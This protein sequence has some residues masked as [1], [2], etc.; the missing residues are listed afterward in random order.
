MATQFF[1]LLP[2]RKEASAINPDKVGRWEDDSFNF[3]P[4]LVKSLASGGKISDFDHIDSIPDVWARPLLFQMAL[5]DETHELHPRIL[6]EWRSILA[7]LALKEIRHL[8][9]STLDVHLDAQSG[10]I[11]QILRI[12]APEDSIS[13]STNWDHLYVIYFEDLPLAMTSPTTLVSTAADYPERFSGILKEPWSRDNRTLTDPIEF[14]TLEELAALRFWI[15][16]LQQTLRSTIPLQD[17]EESDSCMDLFRLLD[18]FQRDLSA[19]LR[20]VD[21]SFNLTQSNLGF[22]VGI[23]RSLNQTIAAREATSDDSAVRLLSTRIQSWDRDIIL[24]SPEMVRDFSSELGIPASQLTIWQGISANDITEEFLNSG[25]A[26]RSK[27]GRVTL[28]DTNWIRPEEFFTDQMAVVEPGNAIVGSIPIAGSS[29]LEEEDLTA[30]L[31][32]KNSLLELFD[33]KE[34]A[35][36]ISLEDTPEEI[37]V[38]FEFPLSGIHGEASYKFQKSYPKKDLVYLQTMIPVIEIFPDFKRDGWDKY[39]LYYE[40]TKA[41]ENS[42]ELGQ[43][44]FYVTPFTEDRLKK[45]PAFANRS[46]LQLNEFPEALLCSVNS[47]GLT[48]EV[49][50]ILLREPRYIER[51]IDLTWQIGIDFGTSSTMIYYREKTPRP[52]TLEPNLFQVTDSGAARGRTFI[53]FIPSTSEDQIDGSFLSIFHLLNPKAVEIQPLVDGHVFNLTVDRIPTFESL[54]RVDANLKWQDSD[55]GRK[56]VAAFVKQ[57]CLQT[58][59]AAARRG[60]ESIQWNFSFPSAFSNEQRLAFLATCQESVDEVYRNS[61]FVEDS[62][63]IHAWEESK[64]AAFYFNKLSEDSKRVDTNFTDGAIILDI[65]AGTTDVSIISG[66]PA[67][68]IYHTSIQFAGRYFF[69]PLFDHYELFSPDFFKQNNFDGT[70]VEKF[71]AILDADIREHSEKYLRNLK[72]L[73][74]SED[75]RNVLELSQFAVSGLFFYVGEILAMLKSMRIFEENHVPDIYIGG[76]GSRIFHWITGG[77]WNSSS[78]FLNVLKNSISLASGLELNRSKIHLS[79]NPKIEVAC[80]MIEIPPI[81]AADFYDDERQSAMLFGSNADFYTANSVLAGESCVVGKKKVEPDDFISAREISEGIVASKSLTN[82]DA[83]VKAFN[84]DRSIWFDGIIF[85]EE[86][87]IELYRRVNGYY[88]SERGKDLKQIFVEPIFILTLKKFLEAM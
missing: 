10:S 62:A 4:A 54:S 47:A 19:K 71:A 42:R 13:R 88:I 27:L 78:P 85:D 26:D 50:A 40:N 61:C 36:R 56:K 22:L 39:F 34:I 31:P 52:L 12:L 43:D 7:M 15:W 21:F 9:L 6:N 79:S 69:R 59:A 70:D 65:G 5:F 72:N 23:F 73:T 75:V 82:F 53:N 8:R 20:D 64:A 25:G 46:I 77:V 55:V 3:L 80:G 74:G 48:I 35:D 29:S 2:K 11:E 37:I 41:Q 49:G 51:E 76:N 33:A 58:S 32:I 1:P 60:V 30:I 84:A 18:E 57:I 87:R 16:N 81:N 45:F 44:F 24:V 63:E 17:Q 83:F 86:S 28:I 14:L 68:T 38:R 66:Q 67:R